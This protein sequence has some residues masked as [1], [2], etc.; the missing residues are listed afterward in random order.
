M[1]QIEV[2]QS[3]S[4][5]MA[6]IKTDLRERKE[7]QYKNQIKNHGKLEDILFIVEMNKGLGFRT[8]SVS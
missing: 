4:V 3:N 2:F 8:R 7:H 1:N 6:V 5:S